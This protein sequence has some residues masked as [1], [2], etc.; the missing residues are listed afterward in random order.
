MVLPGTPTLE[1]VQTPLQKLR[2]IGPPGWLHD[3]RSLGQQRGDLRHEQGSP[4]P[5]GG[6][7]SDRWD[8]RLGTPAVRPPDPFEERQQGYRP[9][10]WANLELHAKWP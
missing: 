1:N 6:T 8:S 5:P 9:A 7:H 3:F 10:A 4:D 2:W